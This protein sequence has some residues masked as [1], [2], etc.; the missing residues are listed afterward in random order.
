[1]LQR[2]PDQRATLDDIVNDPWLGGAADSEGNA[3]S[4]ED[5][6]PMVS[7]EHLTE[8]E[9]AYILKKMVGG[10]IAEKDE[11]IAALDCNE[12]N[13]VTATYFL[14]AERLLSAQRDA[15][16]R[17][18]RQR[19]AARRSV[20]AEVVTAAA[21]AGSSPSKRGI[22]ADVEEEISSAGAFTHRRGLPDALTKQQL[23]SAT[24][25]SLLSPEATAAALSAA[26]AAGNAGGASTSVTVGKRFGG[27][28]IRGIAIVEEE[29][30]EEEEEEEMD[31][32]DAGAR[33]IPI[34]VPAAISAVG[35]DD[36]V[37]VS[38]PARGRPLSRHS[39]TSSLADKSADIAAI[40]ITTLAAGLKSF[41]ET[42]AGSAPGSGTSTP[43]PFPV[44]S[45]IGTGGLSR[46]GSMR[47][48]SGGG[49][50]AAASSSASTPSVALAP[51][52]EAA[53]A[54]CPANAATSAAVLSSSPASER[55]ASSSIAR[56]S[57]SSPSP[58]T[59]PGS[60]G[61]SA[62]GSPA[63]YKMLPNKKLVATR[64]SPQLMLNQVR[65][66]GPFLRLEIPLCFFFYFP[67]DPRGSGGRHR[68]Q[69]RSPLSPLGRES[70]LRHGAVF[71]RCGPSGL[72]PYQRGCRCCHTPPGAAQA[73]AQGQ[74]PVLLL[75]RRQR[76][77]RRR[78]GEEEEARQ[79][80][81]VARIL[82]RRIQEGLSTR[83]F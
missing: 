29:D 45:Q 23:P 4:S 72:L 6:L 21:A 82:R 1:M 32:V 61:S 71:R 38:S 79:I 2:Q 11:I 54:P 80:E 83:R 16:A 48:S 28:G 42:G 46:Q 60:N 57:S 64:S 31:E 63:R 9:H 78:R 37:V 3:I 50:A 51:S 55:R 33:G 26:S 18:L 73:A 67:A 10:G 66:F 5:Q 56:Q 35:D 52:L 17:Q 41:Q 7:R 13:H 24:V 65:Y 20:T 44:S 39:S 14:L 36:D 19:R 8:E 22:V 70:L 12:Y 43:A 81:D 58:S 40:D 77:R 49:M 59:P 69:H 53:A 75:L 47:K 74:D 25:D 30:E 15:L 27:G 34:P 62:Q 68:L 76:R